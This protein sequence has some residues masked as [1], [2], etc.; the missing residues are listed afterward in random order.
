MKLIKKFLI[1]EVSANYALN[2][3][4]HLT[5]QSERH[6]MNDSTIALNQE[7][8]KRYEIPFSIDLVNTSLICSF[9]AQEHPV[10][11][12]EK[13]DYHSVTDADLLLDL[14]FKLEEMNP[15]WYF[16]PARKNY[17]TQRVLHL[18]TFGSGGEGILPCP[19]YDFYLSLT[20]K[21]Y[22]KCKRLP[23]N[24][25]FRLSYSLEK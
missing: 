11:P 17:T 5:L 25:M 20:E 14:L 18:V 2:T 8:A 23:L 9:E 15:M 13:I 7:V 3:P 12:D 22:Q 6:S 1:T 21:E 10:L 19:C 16:V 4:F 24:T